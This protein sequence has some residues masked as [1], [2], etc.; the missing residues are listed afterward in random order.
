MRILTLIFAFFLLVIPFLFVQAQIPTNGLIS[1]WSFDETSGTTISDSVGT[2]NGTLQ[3][4]MGDANWVLGQ[5]G[6]ALDFD[7]VDDFVDAGDP[8]G[9]EFDFGTGDFSVSFWVNTDGHIT[10]PTASWNSIIS[11][12]AYLVSINANWSVITTSGN[13]MR[14]AVGNESI[15]QTGSLSIGQWHHAVALR[16]S[17]TLEL[18]IDGALDV[19]GAGSDDITNSHPLY[20]GDDEMLLLMGGLMKSGSTT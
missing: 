10:H 2:N 1:H 20:F 17:G 13:D 6:G 9:T 12:G 7:G 3:G 5:V 11:K 8:P 15:N 16:R 19:S 14:F 4:G 18:Y